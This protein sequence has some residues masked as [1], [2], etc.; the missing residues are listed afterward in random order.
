MRIKVI[1]NPNADNGRG[2]TQAQVIEAAARP[3]GGVDVLMTEAPNHAIEL[4]QQAAAAGTDVIVAA[5]G[6]GTIGDVVN[7]IIQARQPDVKLGIIPIGSGNDL[8]WDLGVATDVQTAVSRIFNGS[9]MTIDLAQVEDD[10]GRS[11]IIGNNFGIGFLVDIVIETERI[12]R[13]HGFLKYALAAVRTIIR[14]K[15]GS[16]LHLKYDDEAI[17]GDILFMAC[18]LGRRH[19]GGFLITPDAKHDDDLIDSCTATPISRLMMIRMLPSIQTGTHINASFVSMRQN[20]VISA[21]SEQPLSI[22]VDGEVFAYPKDD[23]HH[24]TVTSMPAALNVIV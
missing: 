7:G 15:Q 8:A 12:S 2:A 3:F 10:H 13:V 1:L 14:F 9:M 24:V 6:D 21:S 4:A 17:E 19:G 11:R 5:G 18:G 16:H 22:H 23:V 20:R